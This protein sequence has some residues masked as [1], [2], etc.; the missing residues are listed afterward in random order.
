M[1]ESEGFG[2]R[3]GRFRA[4]AQSWWPPPTRPPDG[5][6][7]IVTIVLDDVGFAQLGCYGSDIETPNIDL[8]AAGGLRYRNFHTTALCS[9]TRASLLTGRN[10]HSVGMGRVTDLATGF[11]G[12][13]ARIPPSAGMLPEM[14]VPAGYAAYAVGKWHLVPEEDLHLGSKRA[15]WPLGRGF[16]RFY[17]FFGGET[18][19]FEP[20]L[21]YDNHRIAPPR[22]TAEGYLL[23]EDLID[24]AIEFVADL[25]HVQPDQPY[26]LHLAL[27]ACHS[28]HQAP[29]RWLDHYRG[30]FDQGWDVWRDETVDRQHRLGVVPE[31]V[32]LSP[33][34]DWVPA[35]DSLDADHRRLYA[36]YMECFAAMLSHA[37]EQIGRFVQ[38]LAELGELDD[39]L[40]MVLS[41]NGA[42][43]EGGPT[44][45]INDARPWNMADR[46]FAEALER[47]DEIGG[48]TVH[49]N[50]P[51]GWT[52]AGN[53]PFRR[54]KR[55]V[56]EGGVC[57]P[58]IVHWPNRFDELGEVGGQIRP[59]YVHVVDLLPTMLEAA[60]VSAPGV[61]GGIDQMPIEGVSIAS[62]FAS[63]DADEVRTT[64][65][66]EMLGSR[67][68]YHDG[69]KAVT[70][71]SMMD[72]QTVSDDDVWELYDVRTDPAE[73]DDRAAAEPERL[74]HM[75]DLWWGEAEAHQVLPLDSM[76]FFEAIGRDPVSPARSHYRYWPGTGPVDEAAAVDIRSRT[77]GVAVTVEI[78]SP[79]ETTEGVLV[80][81]GSGY[82]GWAL[83]LAGGRLHYAH[84][85]VGMEESRIVADRPVEPGRHILGVRYEHGTEG[86]RGGRATLLVDTEV[87]GSVEIPAFTLTRWS[88][89]G[90]GLT[91]GRSMALPVVRD[92]DSPFAFTGT[93]RQVD[94]IVDG[95]PVVD[96]EARAEQ[97]MRAQ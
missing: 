88:I 96:V 74:Q 14:L 36:R 51:W 23:S 11:P 13:D 8:L 1:G 27:G 34:P 71:V 20:A 84:N 37:D 68:I 44:G 55:E 66:F 48:P 72:G 52:V 91:V 61:I 22:T 50:Y 41:D 12:Y 15:T 31:H 17:G 4:D 57:D 73:C 16:E 87:V 5:A 70:F 2:G 43:S 45:S 59:Q 54:W 83:W 26:F 33:R 75:I 62:T 92:Y 38:F 56:H 29:R 58:L 42:S 69:W 67:A 28:P 95:Q 32:A 64:Q 85:F 76:P 77:H 7:S 19:Q 97:S 93:I 79:A 3:I 6:P 18:N 40:V 25:R 10:H 30:K 60:G 90:D 63:A 94:V 89:T 82:G 21:T 35:W 86:A 65:Y 39:T 24:R 81:Q 49:N 9:P 53:T 78:P 47:I 46:P 80:S